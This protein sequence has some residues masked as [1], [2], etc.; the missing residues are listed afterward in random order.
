MNVIFDL[1]G[2]LLNSETK[3]SWLNR[4]ISKTLKE[5]NLK[6]NER[7]KKALYP[8]N[9]SKLKE[10]CNESK[11]DP[12]N[13]WRIR[14]KN[15]LKEKTKAIRTH[16][17]E[18]FNDVNSIYRLNEEFNLYI[19]SNSP[20]EVVDAFVDEYGFDN[21]F[22]EAL[23]RGSKIEDLEMIKP[24]PLF[25]QN[26]KSD[27]EASKSIYIGDREKDRKFAENTGMNFIHLTRK[28]NKFKNLKKVV[29]FIN[30][31]Y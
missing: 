2:V 29:K 31:N 1:D 8:K 23:G 11:L 14:N 18:T 9:I 25:F 13:L 21:L 27:L 19:I 6:N 15:Y 3:I 28:G 7:N 10:F 24:D 5:L 26:L 22:E 16:E 4:A 30:N 17:I 12:K 20:Q